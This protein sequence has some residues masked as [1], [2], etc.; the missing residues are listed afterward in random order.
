MDELHVLRVRR[1]T[2]VWNEENWSWTRA[3]RME[4]LAGLFATTRQSAWSQRRTWLRPMAE[5]V[6][7]VTRALGIPRRSQIAR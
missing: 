6:E 2:L 7:R 3:G 1:N 5:I 4:E